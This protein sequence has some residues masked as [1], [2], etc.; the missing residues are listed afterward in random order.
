MCK[1]KA[2][3]VPTYLSTQNLMV[4]PWVNRMVFNALDIQFFKN[5][6][7]DS[8]WKEHKQELEPEPSKVGVVMPENESPENERPENV[9]KVVSD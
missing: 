8:S 9:R 7:I 4:K 1:E 6:W 3:I 5:V 2:P